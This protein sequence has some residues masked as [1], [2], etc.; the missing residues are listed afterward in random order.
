[1]ISVK[2]FE[3]LIT[4]AAAEAH[5]VAAV[6]LTETMATVATEAKAMIGH[7]LKEWPP[8]AP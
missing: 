3:N 8:L 5:A 1:M 7:E 4:R 2:Q 6:A